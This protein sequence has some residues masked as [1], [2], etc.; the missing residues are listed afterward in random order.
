MAGQGFREFFISIRYLGEKIRRHLGDGS[1]LGVEIR[2]VDEP[3]HLGT[4]GALGLLPDPMDD[5]LMVV[6]GDVLTKLDFRGLL[7][8]H[9]ECHASGTMCVTEYTTTVPYGVVRVHERDLLSIQE[10][11][12]M[13]YL[14]NAGIYVLSPEALSLVPREGPYAMTALFS[15]LL[16]D[17]RKT[18]AYPIREYWTDVGHP[19]DLERAE[20]EFQKFFR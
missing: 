3:D 1:R 13:R 19:E 14:V 12:L 17:G 18:V 10:K 9:D 8:Y 2:Y 4:A 11:P 5:P 16:D 20:S 6:N 7:R 15:R